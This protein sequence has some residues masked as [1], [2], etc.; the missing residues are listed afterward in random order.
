VES[1]GG[2]KSQGVAGRTGATAMV[3]LSEEMVSTTTSS[4]G[5]FQIYS[6]PQ[7]PQA[8]DSCWAGRS[9]AP[10]KPC[11]ASLCGFPAGSGASFLFSP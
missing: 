2:Q 3:L 5:Q 1:E 9:G 6:S 8:R 11:V 7:K 10:F 4:Q